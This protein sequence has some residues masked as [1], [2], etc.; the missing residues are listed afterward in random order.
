MGAI[1]LITELEKAAMTAIT[2][3][4]TFLEYLKDLAYFVL[5]S[6]VQFVSCHILLVLFLLNIQSG[7]GTISFLECC[8]EV[9]CIGS[10]KVYISVL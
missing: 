7:S 5:H 4:G 9:G 2:N 10:S 3:C 1:I 6:L 8:P